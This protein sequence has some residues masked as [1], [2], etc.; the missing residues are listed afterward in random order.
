MLKAC[1]LRGLYE[2]SYLVF[3]LVLLRLAKFDLKSPSEPDEALC[4][5]IGTAVG[6]LNTIR[7]GWTVART[8]TTDPNILYPASLLKGSLRKSWSLES[9]PKH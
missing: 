1:R 4:T 2:R 9:S 5:A 8:S 7:G 3:E 6:K